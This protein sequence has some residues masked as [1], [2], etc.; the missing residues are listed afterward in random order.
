MAFKI[1]SLSEVNRNVE[2]G[3][4]KAFYGTSGVL[5]VTFI[6]I[7]SK[8]VAGAVYIVVLL[9]AAM[10][11]NFFSETADVDGLVNIASKYQ[12]SPKPASRARGRVVVTGAA[13]SS[14]AAGTVLVEPVTGKE[15]EVLASVSIAN[16]AT[17][18]TAQV[19]AFEF[20][21][22][23]NLDAS[24]TLQFRDAT[25]NGVT[26]VAVDSEGIYGGRSVQ[27]TVNGV[28]K[29]WGESIEEFR[30]RV[31]KREQNSPQG[32]SDADYWR[33]AMSFSEVSNCWV[34]PNGWSVTNLVAI[35]CADF[36]SS[37]ISLNST[38]LDDVRQYI[39][40]N[41][42]RPATSIPVI[43]TVTPIKVGL[44]VL[45]PVLNDYYK[46]SVLSAVKAY[47]TDLGPGKSFSAESIRQYILGKGVDRASISEVLIGGKYQS[48][49][50]TLKKYL[51]GTNY[52]NYTVEG[53]VV[54]VNTI[55]DNITFMQ[56]SS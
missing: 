56:M 44:T 5:R 19:Y 35:F 32:G 25:P 6:K 41:N 37:S 15:Y 38:I 52:T 7:L 2:N 34:V 16:G 40:S 47:F 31:R 49:S 21:Q 30:A 39:L 12:M 14:V 26:A 51:M 20:G 24:T 17:T 22:E 11:K 10:W 29:A 18:A 13:G 45:I 27:V 54:N 28:V 1:P 48:G 55:G 46:N 36:N 43:G 8:V 3:F 42:R 4:S 53:E 33:W 9:L 23:Y 50:Y